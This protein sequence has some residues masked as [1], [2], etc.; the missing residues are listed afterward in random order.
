[1]IFTD[2]LGGMAAITARMDI[3]T[4]VL[5]ALLAGADDALWITD[6]AVPAV[7]DRLQQAESVGM[8]NPQRI[9]ESVLRVARYKG[10]LTC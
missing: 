10:T 9:D 8:L 3:Q 2:D 1:V 6:Q 5:T 4:A 7:L